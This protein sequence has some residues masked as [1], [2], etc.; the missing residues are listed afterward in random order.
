MKNSPPILGI[1]GGIGSGKSTVCKIFEILGAVTYYAD[2]RAKW[3]MEHDD[4]LIQSIKNLFGQDA[5]KNQRLDRTY[6]AKQVFKNDSLLKTLNA[7]V[8]PVVGKDVEDWMNENKN[9]K[10]LL[11][12]AALIFE[13]ESF[14]SLDKVILVTAPDDIRIERVLKRDTHRNRQDIKDIMDKQMTDEEKIS[15]ADYVI[16][17]DE[18]HSLIKQVMELF[19]QLIIA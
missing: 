4:N 11:K 19:D 10:L 8:H 1:T 12:E 13:T 15:L 18:H 17:N 14:R 3:L 9:A 2:D 6:I 5:Y 7:L 16:R